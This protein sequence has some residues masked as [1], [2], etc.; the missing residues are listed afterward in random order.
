MCGINAILD[1]ERKLPDKQDRVRVMNSSMVY[2]GPD[3]EGEYGD[4]SIAIAMRRLSIIDVAGGDQPL[5]NEDH[6]LVLVCNGEIYNYIELQQ[7]LRSKGH[8]LSSLSDCEVILHLYEDY[9]T[10]C[11]RKMR[12]MFGFVLWDIK[13]RRLFAA[14]GPSGIKPLYYFEQNGV[15]WF[16]SELKAIAKASRTPLHLDGT[17]A[18]QYLHYSYPIDQRKTMVREIV[19]LLPGEYVVIEKNKTMWRRYWTPMFGVL[20]EHHATDAELREIIKQTVKIH[21][22]SDVPLAL[23]LSS[24]VDSSA[25]AAL[26]A[27]AGMRCTALCAGFVDHFRDDERELALEYAEHLGFPTMEIVLDSH[28][29]VGQFDKMVPFCDEPVADPSSVVQW[30]LY[31]AGREDGF[32]VL[33]SGIGGDEIFFGYIRWNALGHRWQKEHEQG[34]YKRPEDIQDSQPSFSRAHWLLKNLSRPA[35]HDFG[36]NSD[37]PLHNH[38]DNM[39]PG[40]DAIYSVLIQTYLVNNGLLLADKLGMGNSVEVRVPFADHVL[41]EAVLGLPLERRFSPTQSKV[42]SKR[43]LADCLPSYVLNRPKKG[44]S[45]PTRYLSDL[46][47]EHKDEICDGF[48]ASNWLD[49]DSVARLLPKKH[50]DGSF[51]ERLSMALRRRSFNTLSQ[52]GLNRAAMPFAHIIASEFLYRILVFEEWLSLMQSETGMTLSNTIGG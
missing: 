25:I 48:I 37:E 2:R 19:R 49:R 16:S 18:W 43:I 15:H 6:S 27:E 28:E 36:R 30:V 42:L 44:F 38:M 45:V 40:P 1:F 41:V 46:A 23:L 17:S 8:K 26:I 33:L 51:S 13:N 4:A 3:G 50:R 52:A 47:F 14:R 39:A 22:R 29:F 24:G 9:G 31:N 32:K 34:T 11:L 35:F 7:E 12:G 20:A 5:F 21:L 10:E